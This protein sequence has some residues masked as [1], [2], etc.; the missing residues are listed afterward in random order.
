MK[1]KKEN[2]KKILKMIFLLLIVSVIILVFS[3]KV[4]AKGIISGILYIPLWV[5]KALITLVVFVISHLLG[6]VFG[7]DLVALN[8]EDFIFNKYNLTSLKVFETSVTQSGIYR[9]DEAS[10]YIYN[11]VAKWFYIFLGIAFILEI[12]V[13]IYIAI[14]TTIRTLKQDPEKDAEVK[15]MF[16]DFLLGLVVLAGM[17]VFIIAII[18]INNVLVDILAKALDVENY[19][20]TLTFQ[21]FED[22]FSFDIQF[23]IMSLLLYII[24]STLGFIFF[25][26]Y[27]KRLL[28]VSF[29]IIIAPLVAVTFSIDRRRGGAEKL[30][31]WTKMFVYSVLIQ[32]IHALIYVALLKVV[33]T[34]IKSTSSGYIVSVVLLIGGIKFVWDAEKII[35]DLFGIDASRVAASSGI[36]VAILSRANS[37]ANAKERFFD[38]APKL[39]MKTFDVSD[40][41]PKLFSAKRHKENVINKINKR[42]DKKSIIDKIKDGKKEKKKKVE[43]PKRKLTDKDI[44]TA[45]KKSIKKDK[46]VPKKGLRTLGPALK[47][48][49]GI[50]FRNRIFKRM[51]KGA[52]KLTVGAIAATASHATPKFGM[53]TAAYAGAKATGWAIN[54][55]KEKMAEGRERGEGLIYKGSTYMEERQYR[56]VLDRKEKLG[57]EKEIEEQAKAEEQTRPEEQTKPEEPKDNT[58]KEEKEDVKEKSCNEDK[59]DIKEDDSSLDAEKYAK[60]IKEKPKDEIEQEYENS[61]KSWIQ[62]FMNE[63]GA[64]REQAEKNAKKLQKDFLKEKEF[65][66]SILSN[67]DKNLLHKFLNLVT[68]E[69]IDKFESNRDN[70]VKYDVVTKN[71]IKT[72]KRQNEKKLRKQNKQN[73][74]NK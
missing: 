42:S 18:T 5:F 68:K 25:V 16:K 6:L 13:L 7:R 66:Y 3:S 63:T 31:I 45:K 32:A 8:V 21:L 1:I 39:R 64:T 67:T 59:D 49:A 26:Y 9:T 30:M 51:L 4:F 54:K 10:T 28:K 41:K 14:N 2:K 38:K 11:S 69:K 34:D 61:Y 47:R 55:G 35:G 22:S 56:G 58:D 20:D 74:K 29:L 52:A 72:R 40:K 12:I 46:K 19:S 50:K 27:L 15:V 23:G 60:E 43:P 24:I 36:I 73:K 62:N 48:S 70:K 44:E 53:F 17:S 65:N 37:I 33:I 71:V 57:N